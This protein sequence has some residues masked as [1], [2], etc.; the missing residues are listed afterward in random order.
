VEIAEN[1][2]ASIDAAPDRATARDRTTAVAGL[3]TAEDRRDTSK[4]DL[5]VSVLNYLNAAGILR[6]TPEGQLQPLPNMPVGEVIGK[7]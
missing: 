4:R 7:R 3:R 5:Q 2:I 1:R 6:L